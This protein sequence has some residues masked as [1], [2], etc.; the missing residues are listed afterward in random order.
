MC[1]LCPAFPHDPLRRQLLGALVAV[2]LA[3]CSDNALTGRRQLDFVSDDQ[4]ARMADQAWAQLRAEAPP[5]DDGVL[6][7]RL[8][9]IGRPITQAAGRGDLA[10]EFAVLESPELNAVVLPNGKVAVFR[11]MMDFAR[12]DAE[13]GAV[14]GHEVAHILARHPAE[15]VSQQLAAQA[16][17]SLAQILLGGEN[18]ENA[19]L[20]ASV[21]GLGAAY[22]V[23]LPYSRRHELEADRLG[24]GLMRRAGLDPRGA[25]RLWERMAARR[26]SRLSP[27]VLSTHPADGRRLAALREAVAG[28]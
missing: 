24:V 26:E 2:P 13:L 18:G 22:G 27:E 17:V 19:E 6:D 20:V 3:A 9:R 5:A 16:G 11:G 23:L 12:D 10:W 21:F 8:A 15:R 25:L 28:A 14:V 1:R 4:L 7:A